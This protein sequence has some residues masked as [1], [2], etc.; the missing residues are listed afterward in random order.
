MTRQEFDDKIRAIRG[1]QWSLHLLRILRN[2]KF[3]FWDVWVGG[4]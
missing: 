4:Y 1:V 3:I 2:L